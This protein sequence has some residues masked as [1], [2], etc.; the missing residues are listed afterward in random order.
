MGT[1]RTVLNQSEI[2]ICTAACTVT[3]LLVPS[4]F[5]GQQLCVQ[6]DDNVATV[7]TLAAI[8]SMSYENTARTSY[9]AVNTPLSSSGAVGDQICIVAK[10]NTHYNVFSFTGTWN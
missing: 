5:T 3:P 6:N 1:S 10:D 7:I 9:K 2:F 4:G 8:S